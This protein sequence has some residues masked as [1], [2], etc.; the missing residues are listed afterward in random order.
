L[1]FINSYVSTKYKLILKRKIYY[2]INNYINNLI[3]K[4]AKMSN[5]TSNRRMKNVTKFVPVVV[6]TMAL[7][8][9][10]KADEE[11]THK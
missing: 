4:L 7:W 5:R 9:G 3:I 11:H 8:Q 10:K 2:L 1:I 6:G